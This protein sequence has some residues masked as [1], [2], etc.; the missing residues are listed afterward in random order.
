VLESVEQS[1]LIE[2]NSVSEQS[3]E[4]DL[5]LNDKFDNC[6]SVVGIE[7]V[8]LSHINVISQ[9]DSLHQLLLQYKH[10]FADS[11]QPPGRTQVISHSINTGDARP[12]AQQPYRKS[13]AEVKREGEL[14]NKLLQQGVIRPSCSDWSSPTVIVSKK[15][16]TA[17]FRIDYRKLNSVT[18][19]DS[20]PLR[21]KMTHL[22]H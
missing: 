5:S 22:M 17:R 6:D 20:Y 12:I 15:D 2:V 13:H 8:D 9:R 21:D 3:D 16:K 4:L 19:K 11:S 10:V 7:D 1:Q 14:I 18:V